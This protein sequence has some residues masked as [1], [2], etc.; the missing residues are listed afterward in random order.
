[1]FW[2]FCFDWCGNRSRI[3]SLRTS[4]IFSGLTINELTWEYPRFKSPLCPFIFA[5]STIKRLRIKAEEPL[6][7]ASTP[8]VITDIGTRIE[9]LIVEFTYNM[10]IQALDSVGLLNMLMFERLKVIELNEVYVK[11]ID[12]GCMARM[13][14][15]KSLRLLG[16]DVAEVMRNS[17]PEWLYALNEGRDRTLD[18]PDLER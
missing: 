2:C 12:G 1:M 16:V 10:F 5:N 6:E 8:E 4:Y 3:F 13:R 17:G 14:E 7:F 9:E 15:L 11:R 18:S